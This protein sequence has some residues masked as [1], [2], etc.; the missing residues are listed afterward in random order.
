MNCAFLNKWA[1]EE[2]HPMQL[3]CV[4]IGPC[5]LVLEWNK[6][7]LASCVIV[8]NQLA[9]QIKCAALCTD[10]LRG[11]D[12]FQWFT[13]IS[14]GSSLESLVYKV[15]FP[16][17]PEWLWMKENE[18]SRYA[19]EGICALPW[20]SGWP[21]L[22]DSVSKSHRKW[23]D[24]APS[25]AG[26][27]KNINTKNSLLHLSVLLRVIWTTINSVPLWKRLQCIPFITAPSQSDTNAL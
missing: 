10:R 8:L 11:S 16:K 5:M 20:P 25:K 26:G 24:T 27:K 21:S 22:S 2:S 3:S 1:T 14:S 4:L 12:M 9:L 15:E 17:A 23:A 13:F 18:S 19:T 7:W 6:M